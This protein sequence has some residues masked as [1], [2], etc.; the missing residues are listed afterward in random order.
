MESIYV[1]TIQ[2]IKLTVREANAYKNITAG[3]RT[4]SIRISKKT[5]VFRFTTCHNNYGVTPGR[6]QLKQ[7]SFYEKYFTLMMRV[8][9]NYLDE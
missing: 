8:S 4:T 1:T 2:Y 9:K 5:K 3:T 7:A 6:W